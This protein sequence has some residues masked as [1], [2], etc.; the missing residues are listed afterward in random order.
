MIDKLFDVS[1][2][3]VNAHN[4]RDRKKVLFGGLLVLSGLYPEKSNEKGV[5][6]QHQAVIPGLSVP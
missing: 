5:T 1:Y 6:R 4:G 2:K 3:S